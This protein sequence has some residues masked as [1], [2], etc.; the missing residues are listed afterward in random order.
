MRKDRRS[1]ATGFWCLYKGPTGP[2]KGSFTFHKS[3]GVFVCFHVPV[4][5]IPVLGFGGFGSRTE[6]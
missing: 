6:V 1:F 4:S 2:F 3:L 5:S